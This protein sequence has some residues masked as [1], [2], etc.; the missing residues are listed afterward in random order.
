MSLLTVNNLTTDFITKQG[1]VR[2]VRGLNFH[3]GTGEILGIVGESGS[4]KSVAMLSLM[5]LLRDNA[6]ITSGDVTFYGEDISYAG[7]SARAL[8]KHEEMMR[9]IRGK[10]IAMIFQDPLTFLN[11]VLKIGT[12]ITEGIRF[13]LGYDKKKAS[14]HAVELLRRVGI[15]DPERRLSQYPFQLSGGMRQRVIVAIA[16]S[17]RPKLL[18]A[19]EPTTALDVTIQAQLL[20]LIKEYA[21]ESGVSVILI[22]HDLGIVASICDRVAVMYAGE[23]VEEGTVD[24]IFHQTAHP[25]TRGLLN[26]IADIERRSRKPLISIPGTPPDMLKLPP[27][28]AFAARCADA[29]NICAEY[30]PEWSENSETHSWRCW[31]DCISAAEGIARE[32]AERADNVAPGFIEDAEGVSA[33]SETDGR[34]APEERE[35]HENA[36]S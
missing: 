24:E 21:K 17:C 5:R 32:L 8:K 11:P 14:A 23:I 2:A 13:H 19:D 33:V 20:S 35:H 6:R 30:Q 1:V 34:L 28:C 18:I 29:M 7:L 36:A 26:S 4:G 12:Q 25:Y 10:E 27:G 16:L 31:K 3:I 22:T 15:S 9:R